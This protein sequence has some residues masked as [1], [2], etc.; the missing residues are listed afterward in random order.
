M[1]PVPSEKD[2]PQRTSQENLVVLTKR[3]AASSWGRLGVTSSRPHPTQVLITL[4]GGWKSAVAWNGA[5]E[6]WG[7][8]E[9]D[10]THPQ[11]RNWTISF[12]WEGTAAEED[13]ASARRRRLIPV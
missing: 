2:W 3:Q 10:R 7:S 12:S 6:I 13:G 8:A 9:G 1:T 11:V 5:V 4:C